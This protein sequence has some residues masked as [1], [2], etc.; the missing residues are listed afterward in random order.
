MST[1][2]KFC[3]AIYKTIFFRKGD[4]IDT[5]SAKSVKSSFT[6]R[7]VGTQFR[8]APASLKRSSLALALRTQKRPTE[9]VPT[10][11]PWNEDFAVVLRI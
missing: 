2:R 9:C 11:K 7:G 10:P 6:L 4:D 5:K 3:K 1:W 8:D